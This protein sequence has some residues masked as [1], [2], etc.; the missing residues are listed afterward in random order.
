LL[1]L[2]KVCYFQAD[3]DTSSCSHMWLFI[4][5]VMFLLK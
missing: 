3:I 4:L 2:L 1:A 5:S